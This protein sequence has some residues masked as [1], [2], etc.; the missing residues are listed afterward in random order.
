MEIEIIGSIDGDQHYNKDQVASLLQEDQTKLTYGEAFMGRPG[1]HIFVGQTEIVKLRA[2]LDLNPG[3]ARKYVNHALEKEQ[4]IQVH[5][6][7]KTWFLLKT[8]DDKFKIGNICPRLNPLHIQLNASPSLP[9]EQNLLFLKEVYRAYFYVA[10]SFDLRLDEGLSNFGFDKNNR[11]YYLDDD[12]YSWDRFVSFSHIL[13]V[14]IRGNTWLDENGAQIFGN[15]LLQLIGEYFEDTQTNIMVAGKL[16]DIFMPDNDRN[17][18][19]DIIIQQLQ[20][21]K[22][23]SKRINYKHHYLAIFADVHANLPALDAVL[24][25]LSTENIKQGLVLG[26]TVGYGPHPSA[27]IERLQD[28]CFSVIKGNH[29]HAAATRDTK[30]GMSSVAQWCIDW[31]IPQLTPEHIEWLADLPLEINSPEKSLK[32]WQAMHGAPMDPNYFYA[33]VYEMT[34]TKNLDVMKKRGIDLCFHGHTH[35]QGIYLRKKGASDAFSDQQEQTLNSYSHSLICPGSVGQPR[36]KKTGAQ[37]AIY[38]QRNQNIRFLT[39]DYSL[40]KTLQ[41]MRKNGFPNTLIERLK[42]GY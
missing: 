27:C 11:L 23:I 20:S 31:T 38:D 19:L 15:D 39:I 28:S 34:Y 1:T 36:N 41:D 6:P 40:D 42:G 37:L 26:D 2:E 5:H 21:G 25:F 4:K 32:N 14:L 9:L 17:R 24:S 12:I 13:G 16:R 7:H 3:S 8:Q 33:Y 10:S 18:V 22:T 35:I 30:R 29:D